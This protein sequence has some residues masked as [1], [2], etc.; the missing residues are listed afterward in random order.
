MTDLNHA[1]ADVLAANGRTEEAERTY[2][3]SLEEAWSRMEPDD[4]KL[5]AMTEAYLA[6]LH[7][8]G[9]TEQA[10][11]ERAR[12]AALAGGTHPA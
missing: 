10:A 2:V 9:R 3:H 12:F 1:L 4:Q 5:R 8:L 6:F 7:K 11:A